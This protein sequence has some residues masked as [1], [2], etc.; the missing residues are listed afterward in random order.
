M[1][2]NKVENQPFWGV[3]RAVIRVVIDSEISRVLFLSESVSKSFEFKCVKIQIERQKFEL[4]ITDVLTK[5]LR[6]SSWQQPG[7]QRSQGLTML[8]AQN[9]ELEGKVKDRLFLSK[10]SAF[11][12]PG[13]KP[14]VISTGV[15]HNST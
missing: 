2:W 14:S 5:G 1:V 15:L 6:G 3:F 9:S 4:I 8:R 11:Y 13:T 10:E 7:S 12:I